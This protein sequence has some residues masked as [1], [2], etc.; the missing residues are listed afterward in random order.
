MTTVTGHQ[1][2]I[3]V[4]WSLIPGWGCMYYVW[5]DGVAYSFPW[6]HQK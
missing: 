1:P 5:Y 3:N 4:R 2:D 6:P